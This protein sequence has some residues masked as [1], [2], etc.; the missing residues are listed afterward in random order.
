MNKYTDMATFLIRKRNSLIRWYL[1]LTGQRQ[2]LLQF[3]EPVK[4]TAKKRGSKKA[5]ASNTIDLPPSKLNN[6]HHYV[7]STCNMGMAKLGQKSRRCATTTRWYVLRIMTVKFIEHLSAGISLDKVDPL[8]IK[9]YRLKLAIEGLRGSIFMRLLGS[10]CKTQMVPKTLAENAGFMQWRSYLLYM[11]NMHQE[12]PKL[13][14][15]WRKAVA[16]M[17]FP[18]KYAVDAAC[19]IVRVDQ[20]VDSALTILH[21]I[22]AKPADGPSKRD[23]PARMDED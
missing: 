8:K 16:K 7:R 22:M 6:I 15:T 2:F 12:I 20:V 23:Q 5:T 11:L 1:E 13:A 3:L 17:F 19:T 21:I 18:L 4:G 14:S 10:S 9:Y